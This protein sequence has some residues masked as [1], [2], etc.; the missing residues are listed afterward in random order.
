MTKLCVYGEHMVIW[1]KTAKICAQREPHAFC[2]L[3]GTVPTELHIGYR[4]GAGHW[5]PVCHGP[6]PNTGTHNNNRCWLG[7]RL[8]MFVSKG[9]PVLRTLEDSED[10]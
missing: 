9:S 7:G 8:S 3:Q 5:G 2:Q 4:C 6:A 10:L 1:D